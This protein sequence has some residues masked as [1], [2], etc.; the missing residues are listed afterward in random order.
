MFL[1]DGQLYVAVR[2]FP[3][4]HPAKRDPKLKGVY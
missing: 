1:E 3:C 4:P 2:F